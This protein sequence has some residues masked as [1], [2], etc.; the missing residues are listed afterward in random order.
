MTRYILLFV[1]L[2]IFPLTI[3]SQDADSTEQKV[4]KINPLIK[5]TSAL[6]RDAFEAAELIDNQ[7]DN[8]YK[9]G[10]LE[11]VMNHRFGL[12]NNAPNDNDLIG[13]WGAA[14][15]RLAVGY[16]VTDWAKVGFGSTKDK[17][18]QEF[19]LKLVLLKQ[20]KDDK[21]PVNISYYGNYTIDA[22]RKENFQFTE[23]RYSFF[24]SVIFSRRFSPKFSLSATPS[25]SHFNLV[26]SGEKNDIFALG[27]GLRY[28]ISPKTA[29]ISEYTQPFGVNDNIQHGFAVGLEFYASN[30]AFQVFISNYRGIL[31]Q[32]NIMFNQNS[33][34]DGD[35]AIGFNINRL[36]NF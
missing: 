28:K 27:F 17:R 8:T 6:E 16:A 10:T 13:I 22:R 23:D 34:F 11:F 15:I 32:Q 29:I 19:T 12:V 33:F 5:T 2:F 9:K 14:N 3:Y 35:F 7:T 24:N 26:E 36:W 18:F 1:A 31:A 20:T 4:Y 25:I 21:F 30:H